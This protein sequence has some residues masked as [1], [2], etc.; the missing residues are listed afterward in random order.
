MQNYIRKDSYSQLVKSLRGGVNLIQAVI[1]P[2]QVGKTTLALQLFESWK[3]PKLYET[4]DQPDT[5]SSEWISALGDDPP[6]E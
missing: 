6:P 4:A 1:G 2:R 3:G 5:P